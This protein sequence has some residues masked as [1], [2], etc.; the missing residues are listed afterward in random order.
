ADV[1][2]AISGKKVDD[3]FKAA[4]KLEEL[5]AVELPEGLAT[6]KQ[7]PV[8]FTEVKEKDELIQTV[9]AFAD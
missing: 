6:L 4:A 2:K 3:A 5:T 7:K 8:R 1:L 9:L